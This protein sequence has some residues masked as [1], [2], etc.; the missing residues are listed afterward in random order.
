[1]TEAQTISFR[2]PSEVLEALHQQVEARGQKQSTIIINALRYALGLTG[3]LS[4]GH[5]TDGDT[6]GLQGIADRIG[7]L[8]A[9]V[10]QHEQLVDTVASLKRRIAALESTTRPT[11]P[12]SKNKQPHALEAA[13]T[14]PSSQDKPHSLHVTGEPLTTRQAFQHLGGDLS[15]PAS[16]VPNLTRDKHVTW[17]TFRLANQTKYQL[18]GFD[19]IE[20]QREAQEPFL[21]WKGDDQAGIQPS[22]FPHEGER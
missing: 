22:L 12:S 19:V 18:F 21:V 6:P 8:E 7:D 13:Q 3:E 16:R 11:P 14:S 20:A 4:S 2:C 1:M 10:R 17:N 5:G 15:D 9:T